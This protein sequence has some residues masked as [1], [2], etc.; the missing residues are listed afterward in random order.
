MQS[1]CAPAVKWAGASASNREATIIVY[2]FQNEVLM[3]NR[4]I[5]MMDK[6]LSAYSD[7]HIHEYLTRVT[8]DGLTE[9]GFPRLAANIGILIA[10]GKRKELLPTL[11][12]MMELCCEQIP[13]TRAANEFSVR[14][15]LLSINELVGANVLPEEQTRRWKCMLFG[16]DPEIS[17]TLF[18]R[19]PEDKVFNWG[20]FAAVSEYTRG[21]ICG[22]DTAEFVDIQMPPQLVHLD[23]NGMYRDADTNPPMVY[24]LVPR[25]LFSLLLHLGYR[26]RY[27]K[28]I[29]AALKK[30]GL[31]TLEMQSVTGEAPFG[32]RSNQ[33]LHNE[34]TL[35]VI[36]EYEAARYEKEGNFKLRDRFI[37]A[38]NRALD[39][40]DLWLEREPI[41]HVKNRFPSESSYGCE[42]YA[43][44]DKYMIT[45][46]SCLYSASLIGKG[47]EDRR[48]DTSDE[49]VAFLTSGDFHKLFLGAGGYHL[50]FDTSAHPKYDA[51]GLG[52]VHRLGAPSDICL[53]VPCPANPEYRTDLKNGE[54]LSIAPG[55]YTGDRWRFASEENAK[56][57]ILFCGKEVGRADAKMLYTL[58]QKDSL[59]ADY[60]VSEDGV[61]IRVTGEGTLGISLPALLTDG[62]SIADLKICENQAV[63][64]WRGWTCTYTTNGKILDTGTVMANRNGHYRRLVAGSDCPVWVTIRIDR[65]KQS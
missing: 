65:I 15:I 32:G 19:T 58:S 1:I 36:L 12:K 48:V 21:M 38:I 5:R 51:S 27:Y 50:E 54:P 17:Y 44:F 60:S 23:E 9:H 6:V 43:Y 47:R 57:E 11:V 3:Q 42:E 35:A 33:F 20:L 49:S 10:K 34:A 41:T 64:T 2:I 30:A 45:A 52:R 63:I 28:E 31:L 4:Y 59:V 8:T 7:A 62:D 13:K 16:I 24:D 40:I 55:I 46:A 39:N 25:M 37:G 22:V 56:C 61:K 14:E 26:G 29:D 53:S 18:A